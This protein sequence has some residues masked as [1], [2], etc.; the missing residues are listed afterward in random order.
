MALYGYFASLATEVCDRDVGITICC[1]GPVGSGS[2]V[3]V[4]RSV[5]GPEGMI[6]RTEEPRAK[7]KVHPKRYAQLVANAAAHGVDECWIAKHPVLLVGESC[8][9]SGLCFVSSNT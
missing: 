9:P 1:P 2:D 7:G 8:F 5:Y 6:T 3:P 4:E